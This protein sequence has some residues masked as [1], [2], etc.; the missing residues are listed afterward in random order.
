MLSTL[1]CT[2]FLNGPG[3]ALFMTYAPIASAA[4]KVPEGVTV[5]VSGNKV[6]VKGPLGSLERDFSS[7]PII[8]EKLDGEV[9]VYSYFADRKSKAMVGTVA[10]HINNMILGATRGWRY[11]LKVVFSHFPM[12]IKVQ[13]KQLVIENFLGRKSKIIVPVP[14][15]VKVQVTKDDIIVEGIDKELVSHFAANVEMATT[16]RGKDRISPHGREGTPGVLDGIYVYAS[17][18]SK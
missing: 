15:G 2:K 7:L 9:N 16:L 10:G 13:G 5:Q 17:E 11:K 4:V 18:F 12:N 6:S 3:I 1:H 14:D 8:I